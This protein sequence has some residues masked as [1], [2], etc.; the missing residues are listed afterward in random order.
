MLVVRHDLI[1]EEIPSGDHRTL[2]GVLA[3]IPSKDQH[4]FDDNAFFE[5]S[6]HGLVG[7]DLVILEHAAAVVTVHGHENPALRV[8]DAT[9][10][11]GARK[12]TEHLRVDNT[13]TSAREHRYWQIRNHRQLERH[14]FTGLEAGEALQERSELVDALVEF[15]IR[16]DL[17]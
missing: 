1:D 3:G 6:R 17:G 11:R 8:G 15:L 10:A 16:D 12:A 4:F 7:L 2:R 13:E 14:H 5:S 9:S